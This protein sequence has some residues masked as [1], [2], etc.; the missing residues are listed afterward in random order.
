MKRLWSLIAIFGLVAAAALAQDDTATDDNKSTAPAPAEAAEKQTGEGE[1]DAKPD[2]KPD[3]NKPDAQPTAEAPAE[4]PADSPATAP[5]EPPAEATPPQ[6]PD[7]AT[8]AFKTNIEKTSYAI[9]VSIGRGLKRDGANVDP[10]LVGRGLADVFRDEPLPLLLT[11]AQI[12]DAIIAFQNRM[13]AFRAYQFE[14]EAARKFLAENATKEGVVLLPSGLQYRVIDEGDGPKP[15]PTDTVEVLYTGKLTD[16]QVFDSS[17]DR[18]KP[19]T[20]EVTGVIPGWTEALQL[21]KAGSKWEL[22]I[23]SMLGYGESPREGG[24]IKP[25]DVL[26]FEIELLGIKTPKTDGGNS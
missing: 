25:G 4:A 16:D 1:P 11:E 5:A 15:K 24:K 7:A 8:D 2:A 12:R 23:P 6:Q 17:V 26:V 18:E 14:N 22:V 9:G 19:A 10:A 20:F 21:M 13:K 3:A